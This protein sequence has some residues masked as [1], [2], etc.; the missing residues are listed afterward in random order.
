MLKIEQ[1]CLA[2]A[3]TPSRVGT[4]SYG[5]CCPSSELVHLVLVAIST[6]KWDDGPLVANLTMNAAL[7][8]AH[9]V[10][11]IYHSHPDRHDTNPTGLV[12]RKSSRGHT[13]GKVVDHE[14]WTEASALHV[15]LSERRMGAKHPQCDFRE[16]CFQYRLISFHLF[17]KRFVL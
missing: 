7:A 14:Q 2:A 6:S 12:C 13:G 17:R 3:L 4:S 16:A 11:R 5:G 10:S 9:V 15:K 1:P 8:H